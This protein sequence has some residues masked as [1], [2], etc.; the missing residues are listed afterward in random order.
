M[1]CISFAIAF[2]S[3]CDLFGAETPYRQMKWVFSSEKCRILPE[4]YRPMMVR[5][6]ESVFFRSTRMPP[7]PVRVGPPSRSGKTALEVAVDVPQPKAWSCVFVDLQKDWQVR[8][9]LESR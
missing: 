2:L 6:L 8:T 3:L 4:Q 5:S 9:S 7:G 1:R